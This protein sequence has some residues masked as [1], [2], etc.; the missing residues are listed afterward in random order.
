MNHIK[1]RRLAISAASVSFG[2]LMAVTLIWSCAFIS[3]AGADPGD[4]CQQSIQQ[5]GESI[6]PA[7]ISCTPLVVEKL[8]AYDG[9]FLE[10]GSGQEVMDVA[11]ILLHNHSASVIPYA[12]I[13]VYTPSCR[14][15]F[16][17]FMIPPDSSVLVPE[18]NGKKLQ[19]VS[20]VRVFGWIT[21]NNQTQDI[22]LETWEKGND[23][24]WVQNAS[25]RRI[26][27]VTLYH[28][29]YISEGG[30]YLGGKAF[31]TILPELPPGGMV[32]I[33]P[34]N[35]ARGSSRVVYYE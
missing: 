26:R 32:L 10:D 14:Y 11:A 4:I 24:L 16:D 20:V 25:G 13:T 5:Q 31:A 35:Y 27:G 17:A 18:V 12:Y 2:L 34:E 6:L 1:L 15:T 9:S 21:V 7:P 19:E 23:G 28:R 30:F 8:S 22:R 29:T 3:S 33:F